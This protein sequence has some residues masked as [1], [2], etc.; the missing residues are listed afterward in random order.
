MNIIVSLLNLIFE[1]VMY[2]N[3]LDFVIIIFNSK[4]EIL[5]AK[6]QSQSFIFVDP[7]IVNYIYFIFND[8][9][10]SDS[11]CQSKIIS[12]IL[13][14]FPESFKN[15]VKIR[16][17]KDLGIDFK[18]SNWFNQQLS[19]IIVAN[20]IETDHYVVLDGK[21]HF[22][23]NVSL[24][25]FF[26]KDGKVKYNLQSHDSNMLNYYHQCLGYF[27]VACPFASRFSDTH[28]FQTV[29]PFV[30]NTK[31]TLELIRYTEEK[32][33]CSFESFFLNSEKY[34]EFFF[35]FGYLIYAG[36]FNELEI[37]PEVRFTTI[38]RA[39]PKLYSYNSFESKIELIQ[40]N[41]QLSVFGLHRGAIVFLDDIYKTSLISFYREIF[42]D[43]IIELISEILSSKENVKFMRVL[44][45]PDFN[46][47]EYVRL[48][49][50]LKDFTEDQAIDHYEKQ[51]YK[52]GR[53]YKE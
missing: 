39:D 24:D 28:K 11:V 1:T 29:T 25:Y 49:N 42:G 21:N 50:D 16:S 30:F 40:Q 6:L 44:K 36:K 8:I 22:I 46:W 53:K 38:G 26:T 52:E 34:T 31:D 51:G 23:K 37:V 35:Y 15:Q 45:Y 48:H 9:D 4:L 2:K 13:P 47:S 17:S 10:T 14:Y 41:S 7:D 12:E 5:L 3:K 43:F 27:K 18:S 33:V 32:E 19:K 20:I